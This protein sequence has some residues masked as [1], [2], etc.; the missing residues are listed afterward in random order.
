MSDAFYLEMRDV[1][2]ELLEEFDQG[3][4]RLAR[5][6]V[7]TADADRPWDVSLG[8][9]SF[10]DLAGTARTVSQRYVDGTRIVNTD[11]EV[12]FAHP[13]GL[14]PEPQQT[15]RIEVHGVVHKTVGVKRLPESG[16]VVAWKFFVRR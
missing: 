4:L 14:S 16:P 10:V 2:T 12:T 8:A 6:A 11:I 3:I 9:P 1:A 13:A 5:I 15:D 7:T